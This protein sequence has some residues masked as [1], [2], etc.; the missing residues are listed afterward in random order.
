MRTDG[1]RLDIDE[2]VWVCAGDGVHCYAAAT[3][4]LLAKV[5]VPEPVANICFG[6]PKFNRLFT[7]A[8]SSLYNVYLNTR[9]VGLK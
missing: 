3:G 6:G 2:N 7:T 9:V 5:L 4:E 1:I 8:S